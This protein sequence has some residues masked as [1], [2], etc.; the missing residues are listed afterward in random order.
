MSTNGAEHRCT[1]IPDPAQ[2]VCFVVAQDER[3]TSPPLSGPVAERG[4]SFT[5]PGES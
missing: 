1:R 5:S 2:R 4:R 3:E